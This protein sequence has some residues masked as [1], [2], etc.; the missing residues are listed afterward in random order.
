MMREGS[1]TVQDKVNSLRDFEKLCAEKY[2]VAC[3]HAGL[4][5]SIGDEIPKNTKRAASLFHTAC[6]G[7][8]LQSCV[9]L[10][11]A[12]R[13]ELGV[14]KDLNLAKHYY[15]LACSAGVASA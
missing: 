8:Y 7:G 6:E 11:K 3:H 9:A 1:G 14:G 15:Q 12:Y 4:L 5:F 2:L 10:A 13:Q